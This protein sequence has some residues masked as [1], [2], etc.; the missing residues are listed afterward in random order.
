MDLHL[1]LHDSGLL[2]DSDFLD[3]DS[4]NWHLAWISSQEFVAAL[5]KMIKMPLSKLT[6]QFLE[7]SFDPSLQRETIAMMATQTFGVV[8]TASKLH[9]HNAVNDHVAEILRLGFGSLKSLTITTEDHYERSDYPEIFAGRNEKLEQLSIIAAGG[10]SEQYTTF[11]KAMKAGTLPPPPVNLKKV[12]LPLP[13]Q[14]SIQDLVSWIARGNLPKPVSFDFCT[15]PDGT[16]EVMPGSDFCEQIREGLKR[17]DILSGLHETKPLIE[18]IY[19]S[20]TDLRAVEWKTFKPR[21]QE[22]LQETCQKLR[23]H[24]TIR[25]APV[26]RCCGRKPDTEIL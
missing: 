13:E 23:I 20:E 26:A 15:P 8:R 7:E 22:V 2:V 1:H 17:F 24:V 4:E 18:D 9:V 25:D 11:W 21:I 16:W 14:D 10:E 3:D 19:L 6:V 5:P 12:W